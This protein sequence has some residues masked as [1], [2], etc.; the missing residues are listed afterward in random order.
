[1]HQLLRTSARVATALKAVE[2]V[3]PQVKE[4]IGR[5]DALLHAQIDAIAP[6][7]S[8]MGI[9]GVSGEMIQGAPNATVETGHHPAF[10]R[11]ILQCECESDSNQ[12]AMRFLPS[13]GSIRKNGK[14]K[15]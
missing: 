1:M 15:K 14:R 9:L 8:H 7:T 12:S 13:C 3:S 11:R 2:N 10:E 6:W 5:L 4:F